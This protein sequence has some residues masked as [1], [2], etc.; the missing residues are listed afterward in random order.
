MLDVGRACLF[1]GLSIYRAGVFWSQFLPILAQT[2]SIFAVKARL[3][4]TKDCIEHDARHKELLWRQMDPKAVLEAGEQVCNM[5]LTRTRPIPCD[6]GQ[7]WLIPRQQQ[8][9]RTQ[10]TSNC[11]KRPSR[12]SRSLVFM[13]AR[14]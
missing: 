2:R 12:C 14:T 5:I 7:S 8:Q 1:I 4:H 3:G 11:Y 13:R 6:L 10:Q 9:K